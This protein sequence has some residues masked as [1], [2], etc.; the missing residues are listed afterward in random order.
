VNSNAAT[1]GPSNLAALLP[2]GQKVE[3]APSISVHKQMKP[4][5]PA[6]A[7]IYATSEVI[8]LAEEREAFLRFAAEV[9]QERDVALALTRPSRTP[10][11][12]PVEIALL[13]IDEMVVKPLQSTPDN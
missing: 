4:S 13:R 3:V 11:G 9:P 8:V 7:A 10:P 12:L 6:R 5:S 2:P 1:A